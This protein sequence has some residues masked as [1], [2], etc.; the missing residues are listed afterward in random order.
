LNNPA[1]ADRVFIQTSPGTYATIDIPGLKS[2]SNRII[3]RA[4]LITEQDPESDPSATVYA[5]PRYLLLS[6]Y[7]TAKKHKINVPTDFEVSQGGANIESFGGFLTYKNITGVSGRVASY[8]FNISRYVQGI[9]TRKDTSYQLRIY[10]PSNDS[11]KYTFPFP[12]TTTSTTYYLTQASAN[13][14]AH[15]RVRLGGGT[16]TRFRMRLRIIY[17]LL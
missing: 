10:A 9:V 8:T 5:P 7:D 1:N 15:G 3:H 13:P 6:A 17:S 16:N 2:L 12:N 14:I 11:L 4:E